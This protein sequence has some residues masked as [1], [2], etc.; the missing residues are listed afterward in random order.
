[1]MAPVTAPRM[2]TNA[3]GESA[4]VTGWPF[5]YQFITVAPP[6]T[7]PMPPVIWSRFIAART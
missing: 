3:S 1:M 2:Y 7:M 6:Q 5:Q 4:V